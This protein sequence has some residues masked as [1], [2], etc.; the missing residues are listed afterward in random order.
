M[1]GMIYS[2]RTFMELKYWGKADAAVKSS[3]LQS[4]LYGIEIFQIETRWNV[5]QLLQSHL[6]GIEIF[7]RKALI[8][9]TMYSNRT[10][11]ELKY[12]KMV[13]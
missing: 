13:E 6:Y 2:N 8:F 1:E 7:L 10:F 9:A 4:H 3:T 12:F 11:M 5:F